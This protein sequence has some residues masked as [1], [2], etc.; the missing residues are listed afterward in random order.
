MHWLGE[1]KADVCAHGHVMFR[2]P[3]LDL[4][5]LVALDCTV[6]AAALYLLRSL[7]SDR[8]PSPVSERMFPCCGHSLHDVGDGDV[9]VI[10]CSYGVDLGVHHDGA[11][12]L[13][14]SN[15]DCVAIRRIL[16]RAAVFQFADDVAEF[17]AR[18]QSKSP[19]DSDRDG[20]RCFLAEW[21]RRRGRRFPE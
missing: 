12:V 20:H 3:G 9:L 17:Y 19:S 15:E 5:E 18:S 10:G 2:M 16:W 6:S 14:T 8:A 21:E 13:L 4:P 11:Y 7:S 1:P